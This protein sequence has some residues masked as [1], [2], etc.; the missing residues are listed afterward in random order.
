LLSTA[1]ITELRLLVL[2]LETWQKHSLQRLFDDSKR[3]TANKR[4][5]ASDSK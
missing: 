4:K 2:L 1:S 5:L 3:A